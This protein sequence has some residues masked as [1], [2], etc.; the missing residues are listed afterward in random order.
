MTIAGKTG[1]ALGQPIGWGVLEWFRPGKHGVKAR[2]CLRCAFCGKL[3]RGFAE[4]LAR[5]RMQHDL[6]KT[7]PGCNKEK[8]H[9]A[10]KVCARC[11]DMPHVR[12]AGG[13]PKC[14]KPWM[15]EQIVMSADDRKGWEV[16]GW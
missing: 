2:Y 6:G 12:P 4:L 14:G 7:C 8:E 3:H 9:R 16:W 11:Y 1:F 15:P 10:P 5:A 13:C